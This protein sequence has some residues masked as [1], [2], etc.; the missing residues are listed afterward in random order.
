MA[1]S[2]NCTRR[3]L[4]GAAL[5]FVLSAAQF[6]GHA[7]AQEFVP[8]PTLAEAHAFLG[9]TF[10]RYSIAYV[11]WHGARGSAKGRAGY[12]GGRDCLSE[13][14]TG[15]SNRAF[16]VD[17]SLISAVERSGPDAI[18]VIGQLVRPVG[19]PEG[20]RDANFHLYFPNAV[21]SRSVLN[22]FELLRGSCRQRSKF[23]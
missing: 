8:P 18:Y 20:R 17:W 19:H 10:N 4:A 11:V 2:A 16:A 7:L 6:S 13:I 3:R 23:D 14:G 12:Y 1:H 21:V 15:S 5:A 9:D 22:A